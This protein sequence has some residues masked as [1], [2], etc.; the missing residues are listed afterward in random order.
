MEIEELV[1]SIM[2]KILSGPYYS[3]LSEKDMRSTFKKHL[4]KVY[5]R[6]LKKV[7][8]DVKTNEIKKSSM[9]EYIAAFEEVEN[10]LIYSTYELAA[11]SLEDLHDLKK[12]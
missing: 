11:S 8:H 4:T 3:E 1:G 12:F 6:Q 5:T 10:R 7:T 9:N 2:D